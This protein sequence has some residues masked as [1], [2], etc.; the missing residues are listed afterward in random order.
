MNTIIEAQKKDF[1][2][3]DTA[4]AMR[5]VLSYREAQDSLILVN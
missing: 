5:L 1:V 3:W 2:I 4:H